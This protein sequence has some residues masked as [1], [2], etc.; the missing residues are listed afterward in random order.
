MIGPVLS[1]LGVGG[2]GIAG[3]FLAP[4]FMVANWR[5]LL[6]LGALVA[7]LLAVGTLWG[8]EELKVANAR[9]DTRTAQTQRNAAVL[10]DFSAL[11]AG[12]V[13][14]VN[15]STLEGAL[16]GQSASIKAQGDRDAAK[17]RATQVQVQ[18]GLQAHARDQATIAD[19]TSRPLA[20]GTACARS[21]E[22]IGRARVALR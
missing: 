3:W 2:L 17:L 4:A 9:A 7:F 18:A 12:I 8:G 16:N 19:L 14:R 10:A 11:N 6:P 5:W 22:A 20:A 1:F 21:A 15:A 13:L